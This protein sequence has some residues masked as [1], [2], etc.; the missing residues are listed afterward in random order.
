MIAAIN[1]SLLSSGMS[2][3]PD[4]DNGLL[5]ETYWTAPK[6]ILSFRS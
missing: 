4:D 5:V 2:C 1:V 3:V 6:E